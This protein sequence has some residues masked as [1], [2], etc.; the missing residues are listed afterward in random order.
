MAQS[1][2]VRHTFR[3][4]AMATTF[5]ITIASDDRRYA[6]QASQAAFEEL[7]RIEGRLSRSIENSDVSRI[8]HLPAGQASVVH[9][10]TFDCLRIAL[11]VQ[12]ATYGAFDVAYASRNESETGALFRLDSDRHAIE[13]LGEGLLLDLGGVGKG[14][15]LD[16]MAK[17]LK[18][19]GLETVLLGA[20]TSTLR[21][22]DPP[23]DDRG[24]PFSIGPRHAPHHLQLSKNAVSGS[25]TAVRGHHI[26]DPNN[27]KPA[28]TRFRSWAIAPT[29]A[30]AD[31]LSTAFMVMSVDQIQECCRRK[32]GVRA[33]LLD[34]PTGSL[35]A[36]D[37][38]SK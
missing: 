15:A 17:L 9:P 14:F 19:W 2:P 34:S 16:R 6:R 23:L 26:I 37:G 11:E 22:G 10:D 20:S 3:H 28:Q 18:D 24:W 38:K 12:R 5:A 27:G 32:R 13:V 30:V 21:A 35:L 25:G 36:V 4:E 33:F 8:N 31:A 1:N 29:A 7:D